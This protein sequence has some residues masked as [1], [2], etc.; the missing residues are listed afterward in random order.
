MEAFRTC[1]GQSSC[2]CS[3]DAPPPSRLKQLVV[4]APLI[5]LAVFLVNFVLVGLVTTSVRE[6]SGVVPEFLGGA[7]FF[8]PFVLVFGYIWVGLA[9][10]GWRF[11][12]WRAGE[13]VNRA[14]PGTFS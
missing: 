12:K 14:P 3:L 11:R 7:A 2:S 6:W 8:T 9:L 1:S 10:L 13:L 4:V 5:Y